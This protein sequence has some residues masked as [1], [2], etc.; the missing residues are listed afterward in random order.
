MSFYTGRILPWLIDRGMRNRAIAKYRPRIPPQAEGRVLEI[1]VG[2]GLNIPFYTNKVRHLFALEPADY[3]R[4]NAA[5]AAV[6]APFPVTLIGAGAEN[7]PLESGSIDTVVSTW[8]LCSIPGVETALQEMR[9]TLKPGG[10]LIFME[11]GRAPDA[12]V[13]RLQDRLAP[14]FRLLAGCNPNRP[15]SELIA[16]AGFR[17]TKLEASYLEGPRFIAYHYVGEA[18]PA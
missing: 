3:L 8:S 17:M 5:E 6:S 18:R 9:R 15:M 1:G 13:A 7:I 14:V 12:E 4:A 10:R 11:H 16:D 2:A